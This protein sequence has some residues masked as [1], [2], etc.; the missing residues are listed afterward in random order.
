MLV[1]G[2]T[3]RNQ[4]SETGDITRIFF[5]SNQF[6]DFCVWAVSPFASMAKME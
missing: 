3:G 4:K 6:V 1:S 2:D 5:Q